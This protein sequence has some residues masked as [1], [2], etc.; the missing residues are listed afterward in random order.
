MKKTA[1]ISDYWQGFRVL[2]FRSEYLKLSNMKIKDNI[3][4][5]KIPEGIDFDYIHEAVNIAPDNFK[6]TLKLHEH[7]YLLR[8]LLLKNEHYIKNTKSLIFKF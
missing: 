4:Y 2:S 6:E 1:A 3:N 7:I 8:L 5:L